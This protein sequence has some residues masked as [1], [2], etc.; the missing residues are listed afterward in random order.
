MLDILPLKFKSKSAIKGCMCIT[1][2]KW[3]IPCSIDQSHEAKS[4]KIFPPEEKYLFAL[5][6]DTGVPS[7]ELCRQSEI[8]WLVA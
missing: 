4:L 7:N 1:P 3:N 8:T 5:V 6:V 2:Q